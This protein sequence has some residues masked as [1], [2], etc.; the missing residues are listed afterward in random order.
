MV[1]ALTLRTAATFLAVFG[2]NLLHKEKFFV[3]LSWLPKATVQVIYTYFFYFINNHISFIKTINECLFTSAKAAIGSTAYDT[4]MALGNPTPEQI[5]M[6]KVVRILSLHFSHCIPN[7][8]IKWKNPLHS[9]KIFNFSG[10]Y[11]L[12]D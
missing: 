10:F 11:R 9:R 12:S 2:V 7:Y 5:H 4:A 6:G 1:I 8:N 3:A